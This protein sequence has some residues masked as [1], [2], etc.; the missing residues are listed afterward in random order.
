MADEKKHGDVK[1]NRPVS[2]SWIFT[3]NNYS[4]SDR[5]GCS[6]LFQSADVSRMAVGDEVGESGTP[7]YQG[8]IIFRSAKRL[9]GVR[10]LLPRAHW[11]TMRAG[12]EEAKAYALKDKQVLWDKD[13]GG[14]GKRN[15]LDHVRH[16]IDEGK[17]EADL[18]DLHFKQ[19]VRYHKGIM[20]GAHM[21][22][23]VTV[24][25]NYTARE[26]AMKLRW[27]KRKSV[28]LWGPSGVGKTEFALAQFNLH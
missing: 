22:R 12:W 16:S 4:D 17:T 9:T 20:R 18:W 13:E 8:A 27:G 23:P 2:K 3:L 14:Q 28:V 15:D 19:M 26:F 25:G 7:H 6:A 24:A 10:A 11:E 21:L 5:E 1:F